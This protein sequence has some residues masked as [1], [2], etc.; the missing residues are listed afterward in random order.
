MSQNKL[1]LLLNCLPWVFVTETKKKRD[2]RVQKPLELICGRY[3]ENFGE[4]DYRK[5]RMLYK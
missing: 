2:H 5:L 4:A 3:L 1:I